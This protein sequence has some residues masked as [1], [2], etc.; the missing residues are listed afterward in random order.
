MVHFRKHWKHL[1]FCL[2]ELE[3]LADICGIKTE[4]LYAEPDSKSKFEPK[5]NPTIYVKLPSVDVCK[6]IVARSTLIKEII[7]VY[8]TSQL[9]L[10][11]RR[12]RSD[13]EEGDDTQKPQDPANSN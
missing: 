5:I 4:N 11:H 10:A 8:A 12:E 6:R 3:A 9:A 13:S 2:Q 1:D 7:D